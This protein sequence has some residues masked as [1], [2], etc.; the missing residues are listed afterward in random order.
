M[1]RISLNMMYLLILLSNLNYKSYNTY[2]SCKC[3]LS[4]SRRA[5]TFNSGV[6]ET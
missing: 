3:F 4:R 6:H 1:L 2:P 5:F